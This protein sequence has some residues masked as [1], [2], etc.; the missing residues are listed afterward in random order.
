MKNTQHGITLIETIGALAIGSMML[1]GV[2]ALID[3]A[4]EDAKGQQAAL[5][6][7]QVTSAARKYINAN[8]ADLVTK[9]PTTAAVV[10]I[11]IGELRT[12]NFLPSNFSLTNAYGQAT[13]VLVRQPTAGTAATPKR[14][15]ALVVSSGG[16][17]IEDK[18]IAAVATNAGQGSG[19][20]KAADVANAEGA[21][22]RMATTAYRNVACPGGGAAVLTGGAADGGHLASSIFYDGPG[23]LSTDFVYRNEVPGRPELNSM[24]TPLRL[25]DKGVVTEGADC[26]VTPSSG[27]P[28]AIASIAAD[29]KNN[30]LRCGDDGKW[31]AVTAWKNP[32]ETFASL[33]A[34]DKRGDVRMA[35]DKGRAYM[36]NGSTWIAL[37]VDQFGDLNVERDLIAG[38]DVL[39]GNLRASND[40]IAANNV[41]AKN[42]TAT[43][44]VHGKQTVRGGY[45]ISESTVE[46]KRLWLSERHTAGDQCNIPVVVNGQTFV[47]LPFG[48]VVLDKN[49]LMLIC[50]PDATLRYPNGRYDPA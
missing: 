10:A 32:V 35:M 26:R 14:L 40:V 4:M 16:Q 43:N 9:T 8:Y 44:Q 37:A 20:I 23:Q 3:T 39:A 42:V 5:Y 24:N 11:D 47:I 13:C 50:Y 18:I 29:N 6:Q 2:A 45:I 22:W 21:S 15:D 49:N 19:Y 36:F 27:G 28:V 34:T 48:I 41:D 30:L 7:A 38:R 31:T 46:A 17:K 1:I 25:A 12:Q 33:P